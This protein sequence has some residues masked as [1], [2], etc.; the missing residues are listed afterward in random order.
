[1]SHQIAVAA[2]RRSRLELASVTRRDRGEY[3]AAARA[4]LGLHRPWVDPP[5]SEAQFAA[6]V[7]RSRNDEFEP[8]IVRRRDD[9]AIVGFFNLS[10]IIR[11]DLQSAFLG[12]GGVSGYEGQGY[13]TEGLR[14]VLRR[15]FAELRLHRLEAN[16]QPENGRSIALVRRCGFV[17]EGFSARYLKVRGRWRDHEHW[18]IYA[19][20]WRR[21]QRRS[22]V[23]GPRADPR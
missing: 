14:L 1:V 11:G 6:L 2:E 17:H 7:S 20:L 23:S 8:M 12:F 10:H 19:E 13:M 5:T 18:A 16:I 22:Q 9:G 15:S 3:L 4:S 21:R